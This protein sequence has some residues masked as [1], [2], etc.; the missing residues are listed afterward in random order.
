MRINSKKEN[1]LETITLSLWR[2]QN[3]QAKDVYVT[4]TE[5]ITLRDKLLDGCVTEQELFASFLTT[6]NPVSKGEI[7]IGCCRMWPPFRLK[8]C[9]N[10][11]LYRIWKIF[12]SVRCDKS[13]RKYGSRTRFYSLWWFLGLISQHFS[14]CENVSSN[15]LSMALRDVLHVKWYTVTVSE[16]HSLIDCKCNPAA[17]VKWTCAVLF[18]RNRSPF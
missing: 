11:T 3:M 12:L 9:T 7:F 4:V 10:G 8:M 5:V 2:K 17:T 13:C 6:G 16:N 15:F 14:L 18:G 1:Y